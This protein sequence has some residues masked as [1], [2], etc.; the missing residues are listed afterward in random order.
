VDENGEVSET[1]ALHLEIGEKK[2]AIVAT[3]TS[4]EPGTNER[5]SIEASIK[6]P[7]QTVLARNTLDERNH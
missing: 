2:A 4:D 5:S 3:F 1:R 7:F 6:D